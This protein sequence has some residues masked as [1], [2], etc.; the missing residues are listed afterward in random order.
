M[1]VTGTE[2]AQARERALAILADLVAFATVPS[3]PTAGLLRYV[4]LLLS[5]CG[6]HTWLTEAD[7][8]GKANLFAT[9]GP[10]DE[11]GVMLAGHCDVVPAE[12]ADWLS[13]PFDLALRDGRAY[14][15]GSCDMKGFLACVLAM[16]PGLAAARLGR[17]VHIAV[18]SDEEVGCRG[19]Q[20]LADELLRR[21]VGPSACIVGEP[22]GLGVVDAH[23]GCFEYTTE[24]I[25]LSG[26]GSEPDRGVSAIH[27]AARFVTFLLELGERVKA[28]A[29]A[30]SP[31]EPAW[32]T[33]Q[34]GLIS[35][36]EARNIIA[37]HCRVE[38][39]FRPIN[40]ADADF[41]LAEV[42]AFV[43]GSLLPAMRAV[44]PDAQVTT[45]TAGEVAGLEP[46][47]GSEAARLALGANG[48]LGR[49][50]VSFGT[51]AGIYQAAGIPTVVCGPGSI[52]Q[53]H[54]VDEFIEIEQIDRCLAMISALADELAPGC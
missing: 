1:S 26:H 51:E 19:A 52:A 9:I 11:G 23:K 50:P 32:T 30:G 16:A 15:R 10:G 53:A 39:E 38:W 27:H 46:V 25:G 8:A 49:A 43:A 31:F 22:T 7:D 24:F 3:A 4:E 44:H 42:D 37:G 47:A 20:V 12:T 17:P 18:T 33:I 36:G 6:A 28:R 29:P 5:A 45:E 34:A 14:A 41:V 54:T 13:D 35:G 40:R 2:L 48:G 21:G